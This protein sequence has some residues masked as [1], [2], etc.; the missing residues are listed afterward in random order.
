LVSWVVSH[1]NAPS[2]RDQ[3]AEKLAQAMPIDV[4]GTC[5]NLSLNRGSETATISQY[6]FYLA[7]ENCK[8]PSYVTEKLFRI[9]NQDYKVGLPPPPVPVV[10]GPNKTWYQENLPPSSFIHVND[11]DQPED[12]AKYL[13]F[14]HGHDNEYLQYLGW[15]KNYKKHCKKTKCQLCQ[16]VLNWNYIP[17]E[18]E[19]INDFASFWDK[20]KCDYPVSNSFHTPSLFLFA[21]KLYWSLGY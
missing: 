11:F 2:G 7:F 5:G 18:V 19:S 16:K 14:L 17:G 3:Y 9:I 21:Q 10:M 4:F 20:T 15:R 12:L 6:K 1:C 13:K 8:C